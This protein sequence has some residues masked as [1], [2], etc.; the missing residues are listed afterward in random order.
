MLK[1]NAVIRFSV[2]EVAPQVDYGYDYTWYE[3]NR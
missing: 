3:K 1:E 2:K